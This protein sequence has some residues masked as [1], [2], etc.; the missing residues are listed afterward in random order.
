MADLRLTEEKV[1]ELELR[2][3]QREDE[4]ALLRET[5]YAIGSELDLDTVLSLIAKHAQSLLQA[6]TVLV[7]IL[8]SGKD[9]YTYRA[10]AGKYSEEVLGESLALDIGVCGWIWKHKKPWWRGMLSELTPQERNRW[11][12][13]ARTLLM[14]PLIGRKQFLGGI[15]GFNK[16]NGEVFSQND[17]HLLELFAGQAAIAI[18]NALAMEKVEHSRRLAEEA[19]SELKRV[20]KRLNTVN[21][22]LEY[23][24]LYDTLTTLP[25]RSLFKDRFRHD[26]EQAAAAGA[27]LALLIIDIDRFQEINDNLGHDVGDKLLKSTAFLLKTIAGENDKLGRMSGDEFA[28]LLH[29]SEHEAMATANKVLELLSRPIELAGR[30]MVVTSTIGIALYPQHGTDSSTLFKHADEAMIAA[31]RDKHGIRVFDEHINIDGPGRLTL[32]QDLHKA[33]SGQEFEL[34]YQPKIDLARNCLDGVEALARWQRGKGIQV[35]PDMFI[36]AL[37]QNGLIAAFTYW[38][39]HT[40]I[41]QRDRWRQRGWE[42]RIAVNVPLSVVMDAR[43][44]SELSN[45]FNRPGDADGLVLEITE[46]IFL[47]DY[48]RINNILSE[49]RRF[50]FGFSIDDFGTGH[51]SLARLRQLPVDEI[52]VD[53]SFVMNMVDNKDDEVIVRSTIELAHN[54]GLKVVAEGVENADIMASLGK[55][56]CDVVQGYHISKALPVQV[57][58]TYL[59]ESQWAIPQ[60]ASAGGR[61]ADQTNLVSELLG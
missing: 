51:S 21:H 11:E 23:I 31:K 10:G 16:I 24:S 48:E 54:L 15:A 57:L 41:A 6:E 12:K 35:Q 25:N 40:V 9:E 14:V 30:E 43:F 44:L 20:N 3:Q 32:L 4:I 38:A 49:V 61:T 33:L 56:G 34:H 26:L 47:G 2:L 19:Q 18:E 8:N 36:G 60:V 29:S 46:N 1:V 52:K 5:T 17:L 55:L 7:P 53:R 39:L 58:E 27:N 59:A 28:L 45:I 22:E 50:G 42:I 13:E 37:E